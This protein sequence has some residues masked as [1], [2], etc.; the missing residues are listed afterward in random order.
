MT[1]TWLGH[2]VL[3]HKPLGQASNLGKPH[4]RLCVKHSLDAIRASMMKPC[5]WGTH[6]LGGMG[7]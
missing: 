5:L 7:P 6:I 1:L 4:R 3:F 2:E